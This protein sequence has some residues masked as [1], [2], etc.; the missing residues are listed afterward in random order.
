MLIEGNGTDS[1]SDPVVDGRNPGPADIVNI[2]L[3]CSRFYTFPRWLAVGFVS[4]NS[5]EEL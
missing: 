5:M 3:L 2:P 1:G 4:I